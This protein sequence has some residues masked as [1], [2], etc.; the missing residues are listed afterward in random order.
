M[1]EFGF[2]KPI[3]VQYGY[4][5]KDLLHGDFGTSIVTKQPVLEEFITLFPATVELSLCAFSSPLSS[6]CQLGMIAA[7]RRGSAFDHRS[8]PVRLTGYSMPIFW[9]GLLLIIFFSGISAGHPFRGEF[10]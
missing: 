10:R 2:D 9:W 6:A 4:Y 3:L 8:W 5:L 7:V 1:A